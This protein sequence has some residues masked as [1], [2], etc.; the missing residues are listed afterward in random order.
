M[1]ADRRDSVAGVCRVEP[2]LIPRHCAFKA[3]LREEK[4][5]ICVGLVSL[6][7]NGIDFVNEPSCKEPYRFPIGLF[8]LAHFFKLAFDRLNLHSDPCQLSCGLVG[9]MNQWNDLFHCPHVAVMEGLATMDEGSDDLIGLRKRRAQLI[10]RLGKRSDD[11]SNSYHEVCGRDESHS[12][13]FASLKSSLRSREPDGADQRSNRP[14][15][16]D[17]GSPVRFAEVALPTN[18]DETDGKRK[19]EEPAD[20]VSVIQPFEKRCH[21]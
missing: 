4:R 7:E 11:V 6:S 20:Q 8:A 2:R 15:R 17:P 14:D 19:R 13:L 1:S 16:A 10:A 12:E 9:Q 3:V 18:H 21:P 5:A